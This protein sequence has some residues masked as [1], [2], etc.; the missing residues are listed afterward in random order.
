M[1]SGEFGDPPPAPPHHSLREWE[2]GSRQ[3]QRAQA[4]LHRPRHPP[5]GRAAHALH[6]AAEGARGRHRAQPGAAGRRDGLPIRIETRTGDTPARKRQRQRRDPPHILLTTPEQ[7]A[8]DPGVARR[9]LSVRLAQARGAR[10][11]ARAGHVEARRSSVAR[12]R[13]AVHAGA[14]RSTSVGLS[15]TVAEPDDLRRYLVPQR[16]HESGARRPGAS[17]KAARRRT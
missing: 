10:R 8:L 12:P 15:A 4:H 17:P 16:E 5:R 13:A 1:P 6:L 2:E 9:A 7:L 14:R 3:R 11:A